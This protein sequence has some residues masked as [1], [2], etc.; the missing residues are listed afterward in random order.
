MALAAKLGIRRFCAVG[1][2]EMLWHF[3][4]EF[5][6]DGN[7][8][9]HSDEVISDALNW[10]G[11]STILVRALIDAGWIDECECHGRRVHDWH[12][13]ADQTVQRVLAKR[14]QE[15]IPCYFDPSTKL[16][17]SKM[18]LPSPLPKPKPREGSTRAG[19]SNVEEEE[20]VEHWREPDPLDVFKESKP[21]L[22]GKPDPFA[23]NVDPDNEATASMSGLTK[24]LADAIH[25]TW[26]D[27][28]HFVTTASTLRNDAEKIPG[29]WRPLLGRVA[30]RF[31]PPY[32]HM[33]R[34]QLKK[35]LIN[36]FEGEVSGEFKRSGEKGK[37]GIPHQAEAP[38]ASLRTRLGRLWN[39]IDNGKMIEPHAMVETYN[40]AINAGM[41]ATYVG[42]FISKLCKAG[43][44]KM[45]NRK[46]LNHNLPDKP[47]TPKE[48]LKGP[49]LADPDFVKK[50]L[51]KLDIP[52]RRKSKKGSK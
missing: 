13:H 16:A 47:M 45:F 39:D 14:N 34:D 2:L 15:F 25:E 36:W 6:L 42:D 20:R 51:K 38:K 29:R 35:M 5:A 26:P 12:N 48:L 22:N 11:D 23:I 10:D 50:Q 49:Q 52:G 46:I 37:G 17:P 24:E 9:K 3:T 30:K 7:I 8:G 32:V 19:I 40:E 27:Y 41:D 28:P 31:D 44:L 18:P 33:G 43:R 21:Q 1:I 4:A